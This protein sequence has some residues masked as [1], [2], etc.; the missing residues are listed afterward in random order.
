M[1]VRGHDC[2]DLYLCFFFFFLRVMYEVIAYC[3]RRSWVYRVAMTYVCLFA[4]YLVLLCTEYR[5][6]NASVD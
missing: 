2:Y 5:V 6:V 4:I 1:G 3:E